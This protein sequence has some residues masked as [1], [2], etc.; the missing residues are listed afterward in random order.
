[1]IGM[2]VE[3]KDIELLLDAINFRKLSLRVLLDS[4][5]FKHMGCTEQ[6]N[7]EA[8]LMEIQI[9]NKIARLDS[10]FESIEKLQV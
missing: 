4:R 3:I 2:T 8:D 6:Y 1:M 10:L 7:P 9:K 5:V